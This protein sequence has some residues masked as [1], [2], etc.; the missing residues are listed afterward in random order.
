MPVSF[1]SGD[2][3]SAGDGVSISSAT[4]QGTDTYSGA[5]DALAAL[6]ASANDPYEAE[7]LQQAATGGSGGLLGAGFNLGDGGD[8]GQ[9]SLAD[10]QR[11][12]AVNTFIR[13]QTGLGSNLFGLPQYPQGMNF[14][15]PSDGRFDRQFFANMFPSNQ[16][17]NMFPSIGPMPP[18]TTFSQNMLV[19][20]GISGF[21]NV[22]AAPVEYTKA[23]GTKGYQI[24]GVEV[25]KEQAEAASQMR[26]DMFD[27]TADPR[28]SFGSD[29]FG[30]VKSFFT[31]EE[32]DREAGFKEYGTLL[33]M[34]GEIDRATGDITTKVGK[35]ELKYNNRFGITTY[36]GPKDD[37]YRG[38]FENLIRPA[39]SSDDGPQ[40]EEQV[41]IKPITEEE[42]EERSMIRDGLI[43]PEG[44]YFPTTGRFLRLGLLDQPID[45][46][47]GLL[48][49]QDP[50]AFEAMNMAF[51]RPTNVEYFQDPYDMTGY[52]LI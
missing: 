28:P 29:M 50:A 7:L 8:S 48:A 20:S 11:Q 12:T 18:T 40:Q 21:G 6:A 51:R 26:Q 37:S 35:G 24:N 32:P 19:P 25:S 36:S 44:G 39:Y 14:S 5:N 1:S 15:Y 47:G 27:L 16:F 46:Y 2:D 13:Q 9:P 31:G 17:A 38:P 49:G 52:T 30:K 45:T 4:V 41:A 22:P 42:E 43:M 10:L 33:N 23:D 34:G 3:Y